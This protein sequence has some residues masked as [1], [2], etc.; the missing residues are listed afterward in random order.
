MEAGKVVARMVP[1][2]EAELVGMTVL[3]TILN[4]ASLAVVS[5]WALLREVL[6]PLSRAGRDSSPASGGA[7]RGW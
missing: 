7:W 2:N 4:A 1:R 6:R 5:V 3:F